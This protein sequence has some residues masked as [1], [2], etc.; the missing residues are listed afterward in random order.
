LCENY[1]SSLCKINIKTTTVSR[2]I[3]YTLLIAQGTPYRDNF[4]GRIM[5][6]KVGRNLQTMV[7]KSGKIAVKNDRATKKGLSDHHLN[8]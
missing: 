3:F 4:L 6:H 7:A 2:I 1:G 5:R 8:P